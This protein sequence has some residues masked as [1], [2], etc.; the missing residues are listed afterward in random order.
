MPEA[1]IEVPSHVPPHLIRDFDYTQVP[2]T[3]ADPHLAWKTA[4]KDAPDIFWTPHWGGHWVLTRADGVEEVQ[5]D[6]EHFSHKMMSL[7]KGRSYKFLPLELDPPEHSPYRK[8]INPMLSPNMVK[9]LEEEARVL[10]IELIEDLKEKGHCEFIADFAQRLPITI[11]MRMARLPMED[12]GMVL[13]WVDEFA[14]GTNRQMIETAFAKVIKYVAALVEDR[15]KNPGDDVFTTLVHSEVNGRKLTRDEMI[16]LVVLMFLGGLET[17]ASHLGFIALFLARNPGHRRQLAARPE[18]LKNAIEEFY[19][20]FGLSNT[21]RVLT[22]DYVFKGVEFRKEDVVMVPL[23]M[24]GLDERRW[25]HP[26]EVDFERKDLHLHATFGN[27][28]HKCPGAHLARAETRV[29][30]EEWLKR[31]PDFEI[32]PGDTAHTKGGN[33]NTVHYLPLSWKT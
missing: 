24:H 31:I 12:R 20:R 33:M 9:E 10:A 19:R 30:L 27:G 7:P 2:G 16:S 13:E 26:F 17:V 28:P 32:T 29:F 8:L 18:L 25:N 5:K 14:H 3:D 22:R 11:F 15:L 6:Y 4:L 1:A 23:Y 21:T